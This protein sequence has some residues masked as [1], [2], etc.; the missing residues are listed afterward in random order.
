[1]KRRSAR[2]RIFP[3]H[4]A[5]AE[6]KWRLCI[7]LV[8]ISFIWKKKQTVFHRFPLIGFGIANVRR[9]SGFE[10]QHQWMRTLCEN[11]LNYWEAGEMKISAEFCRC[12]VEYCLLSCVQNEIFFFEWKSP[13]HFFQQSGHCKRMKWWK[14]GAN[15]DHWKTDKIPYLNESDNDTHS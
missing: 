11:C 12:V 10:R 4:K 6:R 7:A 8:K 5:P 15:F 1:M 3:L 9:I 14:G 13:G 2:N